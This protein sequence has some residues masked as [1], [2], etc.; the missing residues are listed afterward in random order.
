MRSEARQP[1]RSSAL[2]PKKAKDSGHLRATTSVMAGSHKNDRSRENRNFLGGINLTICQDILSIPSPPTPSCGER[3][4]QKRRLSTSFLSNKV[5]TPL[6]DKTNS[7]ASPSVTKKTQN[8]SKPKRNRKR[9]SLCHVPSPLETELEHPLKKSGPEVSNPPLQQRLVLDG[10]YDEHVLSAGRRSKKRS[11]RRE[12]LVLQLSPEN[13]EP[14]SSP[15]PQ[16]RVV[17]ACSEGYI[18]SGRQ[19][20]RTPRR[21]QSLLLPSEC[22]E[23]L[24][25]PTAA[26]AK[27]E[28]KH[29]YGNE[30]VQGAQNEVSEFAKLR[31]LVRQYCSL[32]T[33]SRRLKACAD[34]IKDCSGYPL[35]LGDTDTSSDPEVIHTT[36]RALLN[37]VGPSVQL[38]EEKKV[39]QTRETEDLTGCT[40]E[41]TRNGRYKYRDAA[42]ERVTS[43][44]Y[45]L[46][47]LEMTSRKK[48]EKTDTFQL[49]RQQLEAHSHSNSISTVAPLRAA[50]KAEELALFT[51]A[52]ALQVNTRRGNGDM[53]C[54]YT[55][56]H[57]EHAAP[58]SNHWH[59]SLQCKKDD[60]ED[61]APLD[62]T[63]KSDFEL[64]KAMARENKEGAMVERK[65]PVGEGSAEQENLLPIPS[66]ERESEDPEIAEAESA[67]WVAI[68]AAL[69]TYSRKV[70]SI[71][72]RQRAAR[73]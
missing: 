10:I 32:K 42:G 13:A 56:M 45:R 63:S 69:E 71:Q 29:G 57:F 49:L 72:T 62:R 70:I 52:S 31:N 9:K 15:P 22:S 61:F 60:S 41:K 43:D 59:L 27:N 7:C 8:S 38:I 54:D 5:T 24:G 36:R 58:Q 40:V 26:V 48:Q 44:K 21:R 14:P 3:L 2:L 16:E 6:E 39:V 51:A 66:R 19:R 37:E 55:D 11:K 33:D 23:S 73:G 4:H 20:K 28:T 46:L 47:Y 68:D 12:T 50:P 65:D 34:G 18:E 30:K 67:L 35:G 25:I 17:I 1:F 64:N 53:D